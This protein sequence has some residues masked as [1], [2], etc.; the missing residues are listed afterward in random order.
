MQPNTETERERE[1][2][3][4][5][6]SMH[7]FGTDTLACL[8]LQWDDY[9]VSLT[10]AEYDLISGGSQSVTKVE[11]DTDDMD[12][13]DDE[14]EAEAVEELP[15]KCIEEDVTLTIHMRMV[16]INFDGRSDGR[17]IKKILTNIAPRKIVCEIDWLLPLLY[18]T[19]ARAYWRTTLLA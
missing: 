2:E 18:A 11:A 15:T 12:D 16:E 7:H 1:G 19:Y 13:S 17:S 3:T 5:R 10:K 6:E 9:G 8:C 14:P 4:G